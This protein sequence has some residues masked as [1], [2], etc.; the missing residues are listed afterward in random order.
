MVTDA[1]NRANIG[2]ASN[3]AAQS[4][5]LDHSMAADWDVDEKIAYTRALADTILQYPAN[6]TMATL[7]LAEK[8]RGF[9]IDEYPDASMNPA[10]DSQDWQLF[11]YHLENNVVQAGSSIADIG[12]GV[13]RAISSIGG[14]IGNAAEAAENTTSVARLVVPLAALVLLYWLVKDPEKSTRAGGNISSSLREWAPY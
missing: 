2:S 13:L 6:F 1:Q 12:T 4:V 5:G 7:D 11:G 10:F 14:T 8:L 9:T 3:L